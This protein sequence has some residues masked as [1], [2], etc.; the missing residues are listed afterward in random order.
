MPEAPGGASGAVA[1]KP[2]AEEGGLE[3]VRVFELD[4]ERFRT[5]LDGEAWTS[6]ERTIRR[7]RELFSDRT[8][9]NVNSTAHGGGVAEMLRSLVGYARGAGTDARWVVI[10][11]DAD[12]FRV[13]KRIH[14]RLHGFP[15]DG[16]PL[17]DSERATYDRLCQRNAELLAARLRPQDVV[18]LHDPQTAGMV[19]QLTQRAAAVVWRSH[20]GADEPNDLA[21]EAW[22]FLTAYV[23]PADAYIFSR[24]GY[25][26]E[27]LDRSKVSIIAPSIDAFSPKNATLAFTGVIAVLRAVGLAAGGHHR[28][29]AIFERLDGSVDPVTSKATLLEERPLDLDQA[30][31]AQVS[32]WDRLKDPIGVLTAFVEHVRHEGDP[33]LLLAGPDV[34]S[35]T[36]DPEGQGVFLEVEAAWR[37]LPTDARRRVHLALLPMNDADENAVI[38]NALQRR[39]DVV[40]QKSLAEGFGLT[41]SEAMWKARP[42]VASDVGGIR[43]QIEDG[44]TGFLVDPSDLESFG[45]HVSDLIASPHE[46]ERMG[47]AGQARV[48]RHFLGPRHL[49]QY[50]E[51]LD[52]VLAAR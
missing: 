22:R 46:A 1:G 40:A 33:H 36:D 3:E 19:P 31:L 12:F 42:V 6:F 52:R 38:V 15:G 23:E 16:G 5:V 43:E 37:G 27:G 17:G 39:S 29:R 47:E 10:G 24:A 21:R 13:T 28:S 30:L 45:R 8:V 34:T 35:V 9:W 32:R 26:W 18:I 14:N 20:I 44:H 41:V 48:R 4:P 25:V 49:E 2:G 7:G 50:L 51:L 11:G